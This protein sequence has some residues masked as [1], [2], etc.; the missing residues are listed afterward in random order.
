[1]LGKHLFKLTLKVKSNKISRGLSNN[2]VNILYEANP[3][4]SRRFD[5]S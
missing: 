3:I 4:H 5:I 2:L 1:V